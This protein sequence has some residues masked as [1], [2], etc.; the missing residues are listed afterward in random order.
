[1]ELNEFEIGNRRAGQVRHGHAV[2]G[3]DG[4][5]GRIAEDVTGAA[6][7]EQDDLRSN[8]ARAPVF[9][10]DPRADAAADLAVDDEADRACVIRCAH[11]G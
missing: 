1:M 5:I 3:G 9:V 2:A 10:Q 8:D 7:R 11:V 6:G 4:R